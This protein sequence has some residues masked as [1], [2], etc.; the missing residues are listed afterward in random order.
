MKVLSGILSIVLL[1]NLFI[2]PAVLAVEEPADK[3]VQ[4]E[5]VN[6]IID[7]ATGQSTIEKLEDSQQETMPEETNTS[8]P[9]TET[10]QEETNT[11]TPETETAQEETGITEESSVEK[12]EGSNQEPDTTDTNT[13]RVSKENS[14][15]D[16]RAVEESYLTEH[17]TYA[18]DPQYNIYVLT[19]IKKDD[20]GVIRVPLWAKHDSKIISVEF[21]SNF[22]PSIKN[23]SNASSITDFI[24]DNEN[25][26]AFWNKGNRKS[27]FSYLFSRY[28]SLKN[29]D[30]STF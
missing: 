15:T 23:Y 10:A 16:Q 6:Q 28:S 12:N 24:L 27:D 14:M 1:G 17:Y 13:E 19:G 3:T 7:E 25:S 18:Y 22:W 29:V 26:D 2:A 30:F 21:G 9:E 5:E 11:S 4:T 8:T 20:N